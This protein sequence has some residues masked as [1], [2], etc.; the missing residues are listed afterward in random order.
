MIDRILAP[1]RE[2]GPGAGALYLADRVLSALSPSTRVFVYEFMVQPI[3][4]EPV[5]QVRAPQAFETREIGSGDAERAA[6]PPSADIIDSRFAQGA[7]CLGTFKQDRFVGYIWIRYGSHDEDEVRCR[8]VLEPAAESA[9]DFDLYIFPEHRLGLAFVAIWQNAIAALRSRGIRYSYS[10]LTRFNLASRRA[11]AHFGWRCVGRALFLKLW[12]LELMVGTV[13]PYA[14]LSFGGQ[15]P[16]LQL[17]PDALDRS[18]SGLTE[19]SANGQ[20]ARDS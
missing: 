6:M 12:R 10:R 8:Y 16:K 18:P 20:T 14:Y 11:H 4:D 9:F 13:V 1:F 7:I 3:T 17:R 15:G 2:F 19:K 5:P